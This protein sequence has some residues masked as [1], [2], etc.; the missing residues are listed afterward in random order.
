[1]GRT[2]Y[3][4]CDG[5][6]QQVKIVLSIVGGKEKSMRHTFGFCFKKKTQSGVGWC[7]AGELWSICLNPRLWLPLYSGLVPIKLPSIS[8]SRSTPEQ[9]TISTFSVEVGFPVFRGCPI[10]TPPHT[11]NPSPPLPHG[12]GPRL[13]DCDKHTPACSRSFKG[14]QG[15]GL[16][17]GVGGS[18]RER[19]P[20]LKPRAGSADRVA[21]KGSSNPW[22][23]ATRSASSSG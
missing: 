9:Q 23:T 1:M 4:T 8:R 17:D 19:R 5:V 7:S 21:T 20:R 2:D 10:R 18:L 14:T 6:L 13:V 22:T 12:R 11:H 15:V 3:F 16:R